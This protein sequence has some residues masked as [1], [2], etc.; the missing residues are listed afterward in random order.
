ME[1]CAEASYSKCT[2]VK[3]HASSPE[4]FL[5]FFMLP[6]PY[7]CLRQC[8]T[9]DLFATFIERSFS[10]LEVRVGVDTSSLILGA[11]DTQ[12]KLWVPL[13][14]PV[15]TAT[16]RIHERRKHANG[17][18]GSMTT[19]CPC[20]LDATGKSTLC[21]FHT[22]SIEHG[23]FGFSY[24]AFVWSNAIERRI[25]LRGLQ[26]TSPD[27]TSSFPDFVW[28]GTGKTGNCAQTAPSPPPAPPAIV[29]HFG[30]DPVFEVCFP[31]NKMRAFL[32]PE[33]RSSG[34][35]RG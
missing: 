15:R 2:D 3:A 33:L 25:G 12:P 29:L 32:T 23:N 17:I 16:C 4:D 24:F 35:D 14:I 1:R 20:S 5:V 31:S 26:N 21:V 11:E 18:Y 28:N 10:A 9:L 13:T 6:T 30:L 27:L 34:S 8:L 19:P 7:T 22:S